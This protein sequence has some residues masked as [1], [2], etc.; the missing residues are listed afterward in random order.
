[1]RVLIAA[2]MEGISGVTQWEHVDPTHAEYQRFRSIMTN[3]INAV[4]DGALDGGATSVIVTDGHHAGCNVLIDRLRAPAHLI[5][6]SPAPLSMVEGVQNSDMVFFI[7]YHAMAGTPE[8]VLCH[9]WTDQVRGVWLNDRAVGEIGLN[10]AV[11][12][13]FNVPIGLVTGD[14]AATQEAIDLLGPIET[15]V[16]KRAL[17]HMAAECYPLE[18]NHAAIR[19]AATRAMAQALTPLHIAAPI[20]LR[21][22]LSRP[23]QIDRALRVP[24]T[25][26]LSGTQIQWIGADMREVYR[27]FRAIVSLAE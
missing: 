7:G 20:T 11:C 17:S 8:A 3:E 18:E 27:A 6:G 14:Q 2:D 13:S 25:E 26:R 16:V 12:G 1:M 21:V 9:T 19:P 5:C 4:I 15:V 23:D 24:G 10:A 22:E